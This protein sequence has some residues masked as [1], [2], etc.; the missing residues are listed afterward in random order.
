MCGGPQEGDRG[1]GGR[2]GGVRICSNTGKKSHRGQN[3]GY[4]LTV[5]AIF[6]P[7]FPPP[8][9]WLSKTDFLGWRLTWSTWKQPSVKSH[10]GLQLEDHEGPIMLQ[11]KCGL[12]VLGS[13]LA[14]AYAS[15]VTLDKLLHLS[16]PHFPSSE[17]GWWQYPAFG[18]VEAQQASPCQVLNA[19]PDTQ[20]APN[21]GEQILLFIRADNQE[22]ELQK[23]SL[24]F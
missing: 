15:Y 14:F 5:C 16:E 13:H 17:T 22:H 9:M 4:Q 21:N 20:L 18:A 23:F 19:V 7:L 24:S 2:S 6:N 1:G 3:S 12:Q 11:L 10:T 8:S